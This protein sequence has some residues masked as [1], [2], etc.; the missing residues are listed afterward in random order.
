MTTQTV[1]A[2]GRW[3]FEFASWLPSESEWSNALSGVQPEERDRIGR[4]QRPGSVPPMVGRTNPDA[5]S[6]LIGRLMMRTLINQITSI[7]KQDIQLKRTKQGKPYMENPVSTPELQN[8]NFN[9][10]HH[11]KWVVMASE[12]YSLVG[13]DVMEI[14]IRRREINA[15]T[16]STFLQDFKTVLTPHEWNDIHS[17]KTPF[18]TLRRFYL[19]WCLKEAYIKAVGIGLG[20]DLPRA[21]FFIL[22]GTE[23]RQPKQK[24]PPL[25]EGDSR[26]FAFLVLDGKDVSEEWS[27][28]LGDLD[29][30]H[31]YATARGRP[32]E[33]IKDYYDTLPIAKNT[34]VANDTCPAHNQPDPHMQ[35]VQISDLV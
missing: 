7:P 22:D 32:K 29:E 19:I 20:F 28:V 33:A 31:V 14:E 16:V 2:R 3:A 13:I 30:T 4:F 34:A 6:S 27:F 35:V 24:Q 21:D 15:S 10:G 26:T 5:K 8:F 23:T 25:P 17:Q 18:A 11:G 12:P 9:V 1:A